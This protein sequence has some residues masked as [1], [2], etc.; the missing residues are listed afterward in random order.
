[1]N[2]TRIYNAN[3]HNNG[4]NISNRHNY[5][6]YHTNHLNIC[7]I[8]DDKTDCSLQSA[9]CDGTS[10]QDLPYKTLPSAYLASSQNATA[11]AAATLSEST[12]CDIGIF[13]V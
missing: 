4:Q 12:P 2:N 7:G 8:S 5:K 11:L 13:T 3:T 10:C 1:M 6:Q 9:F